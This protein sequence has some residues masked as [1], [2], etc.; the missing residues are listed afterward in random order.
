MEAELE[1]ESQE[2]GASSGGG[3][4][5]EPRAMRGAVSEQAA[6][7]LSLSEVLVGVALVQRFLDDFIAEESWR[8][9]VERGKSERG[10][11]GVGMGAAGRRASALAETHS[12]QR[13][14]I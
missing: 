1:T 7:P 12:S 9:R 14:A 4:M 2:T 8:K 10:A 11:R 3:R 13:R 6:A 5:A